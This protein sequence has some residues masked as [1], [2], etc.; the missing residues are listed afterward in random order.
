MNVPDNSKFQQMV[1][2]RPPLSILPA[3]NKRLI[4]QYMARTSFTVGVLA[5]AG[6]IFVYKFWLNA[7][8]S[9]F[10]KSRKSFSFETDPY[11]GKV[12]CNYKEVPN[13]QHGY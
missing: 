5:F 9:F 7:H 12:N 13:N 8:S 11:S 6:S 2:N 10:L 3:P 1:K 4:S